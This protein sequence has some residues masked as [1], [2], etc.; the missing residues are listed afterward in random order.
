MRTLS[1]VLVGLL[2]YSTVM[3]QRG[4][5]PPERDENVVQ[6]IR[7]VDG[8]V[9]IELRSSREFPVRSEVVVLTIGDKQF[10]KS[11]SPEGGSLKTL[12]FILTEEEFEEL[13]DEA[14]MSVGYGKRPG[15]HMPRW[16]FGQLKK[17]L[18]R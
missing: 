6:S 15:D 8:T 12:I 16:N 18:R 11:K 2:S 5:G 4:G 13:I 14:P 7:T 10:L 9:E 1:V 3:A 17:S